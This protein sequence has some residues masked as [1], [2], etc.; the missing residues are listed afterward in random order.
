MREIRIEQYPA[1]KKKWADFRMVIFYK[2][3]EELL[4]DFKS[5]NSFKRKTNKALLKNKLNNALQNEKF[6]LP[7]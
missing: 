3:I 6:H 7:L 2:K 4:N 1:M 5:A